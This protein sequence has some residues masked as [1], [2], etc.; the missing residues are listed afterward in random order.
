MHRDGYAGAGVKDITDAAGVPKGSFYSYFSSKEALSAEVLT[1]YWDPIE[2]DLL[3]LLADEKV[4]PTDRIAH[5]FR[6]LAD[7]HESH[8][9]VLGCMIGR[10]ALEVG[11]SSD[12]ARAELVRILDR[13]DGAIAACVRAAQS[14]GAIAADRSATEVAAVIVEAWEGAALRGKVNRDRAPYARFEQSTL[15]ALLGTRTRAA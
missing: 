15:P 1:F 10:M 8:D 2:T 13:W 9:F 5:F 3:P 4:E 14:S 6:A 7:E 12:P 11:G